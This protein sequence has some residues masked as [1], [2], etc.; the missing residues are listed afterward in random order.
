MYYVNFDTFPA[1]HKIEAIHPMFI[2]D[3]LEV[4]VTD[5]TR[6]LPE[7]KATA[8]YVCGLVKMINYDKDVYE[9][10]LRPRTIRCLQEPNP[11]E[12]EDWDTPGIE[13]KLVA[14]RTTTTNEKGEFCFSAH[15]GLWRVTADILPDEEVAGY[16]FKYGSDRGEMAFIM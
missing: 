16:N 15:L 9:T 12:E 11:L 10:S 5:E 8:T 14:E 2:F 3:P 6:Q 7:V 4:T 1:K 13:D